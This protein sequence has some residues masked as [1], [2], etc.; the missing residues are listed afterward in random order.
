M[1][2]TAKRQQV[3]GRFRRMVHR[4]CRIAGIDPRRCFCLRCITA[5]SG[6]YRR[7]RVTV[8]QRVYADAHVLGVRIRHRYAFDLP[9]TSPTR[10]VG[11]AGSG[12][13]QLGLPAFEEQDLLPRITGRPARS[14]G[15]QLRSKLRRDH[16]PS[17]MAGRASR[18]RSARVTA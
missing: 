6:I 8:G 16:P 15:L 10:V 5:G 13:R 9:L 17:R 11:A 2:A 3:H 12:I 18:L 7:T 4:L 1:H 14:A